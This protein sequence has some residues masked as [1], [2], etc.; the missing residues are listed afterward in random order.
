MCLFANSLF[1][2][3]FFS[4]FF[5][6]TF[7][8]SHFSLYIFSSSYFSYFFFFPQF[9]TSLFF[10]FFVIDVYIFLLPSHYF[11]VLFCLS[12]YVYFIS[13]LLRCH[14]LC[15]ASSLFIFEFF[16]LCVVILPLFYLPFFFARYAPPPK[17]FSNVFAAVLPFVRLLV[18]WCLLTIISWNIIKVSEYRLCHYIHMK[19]SIRWTYK[20]D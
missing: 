10:P 13:A 20:V 1:S 18:F 8:F 7:F 9:W 14:F 11:R 3:L 5:S 6:W 4:L 15:S 16:S 17:K 12:V 2:F 19:I